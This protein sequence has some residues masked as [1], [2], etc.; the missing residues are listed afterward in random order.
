M[1]RQKLQDEIGRLQT[2]LADNNL[3]IEGLVKAIAAKDTEIA[4]LKKKIEELK[5]EMF[6]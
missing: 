4:A 5:T 2:R 1:A 6:Q 3:K